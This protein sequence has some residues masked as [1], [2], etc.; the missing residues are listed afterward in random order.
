MMTVGRRWDLEVAALDE[1]ALGLDRP[2]REVG[3]DLGM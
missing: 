3:S 2:G 1:E